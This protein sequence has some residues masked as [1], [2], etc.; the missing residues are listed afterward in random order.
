MADEKNESLLQ[1]LDNTQTNCLNEAS[2][3]NNTLR[4]ILGAKTRNKNASAQ[5]LSDA[6]EQLI[7]NLHFNQTVRPR[8]IV[9]H[10]SP[11]HI[12]QGPARI[13]LFIN[14]PAIG[15]E[16]VERAEEPDAAQVI[17][18]TEEQVREGKPIPLR[19]V[20]FQSV[21][22]LHS[23]IGTED[24]TRI[25]AVDV[26]GSSASGGGTRDLSALTTEEGPA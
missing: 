19:F 25:D 8:S 21:T 20:R 1:H 12:A 23:N 6:D 18:L 7:L 2:H 26:L 14:R 13:K 10:T 11:A 15:F 3:S 24:V 17:D 16:D 9:I 22:I 4:S 5:L